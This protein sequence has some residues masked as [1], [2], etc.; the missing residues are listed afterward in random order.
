MLS[1]LLIKKA[2][3]VDHLANPIMKTVK[4]ADD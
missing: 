4:P 3:H 2:A 1:D